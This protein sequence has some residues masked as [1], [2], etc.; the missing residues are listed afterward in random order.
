MGVYTVRINSFNF[1][2]VRTYESYLAR[3]AYQ[4]I[5]YGDVYV[6]LVLLATLSRASGVNIGELRF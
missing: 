2:T 6:L 1:F 4:K 3:C 5:L